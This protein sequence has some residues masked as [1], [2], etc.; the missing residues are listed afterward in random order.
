MRR[1]VR[2]ICLSMVLSMILIAI[3]SPSHGANESEPTAQPDPGQ[4]FI[5]VTGSPDTCQIRIQQ[6]GNRFKGV[7]S[8]GPNE[9]KCDNNQ[10]SWFVK[11]NVCNLEGWTLKILNAP[12]HPGCFE[13]TADEAGV[14]AV[15]NEAQTSAASGPPH[16]LCALDKYGTYWPYVIT[17]LGPPDAAGARP[18]IAT[19]DP[20]AVIFP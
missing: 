14:V 15:M 8:S 11:G 9:E 4:V 10:L 12:G 20:G 1:A 13:E 2:W 18:V 5:L 7:C 17:L 16:M 3:P 6:P 19:T